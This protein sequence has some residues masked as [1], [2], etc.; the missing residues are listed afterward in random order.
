MNTTAPL[1][2]AFDAPRLASALGKQSGKRVEAGA[3]DVEGLEYSP[4]ERSMTFD[5][6]TARWRCRLMDYEV[7][8][9][10]EVEPA[11]KTKS[12]PAIPVDAVSDSARSPDG[13]WEAVV[14]G[15][16]LAVRERATG[17]LRILA[18]DGTPTDTY[19]KDV[20][21][22]RGVEMEYKAPAPAASLP[23]VVWSPDSTK[24]VAFRTRAGTS[25]VVYYV[26]SS[27]PDQLQPRLRSYP[28]LKP[29]DD[30]P[31]RRPHLFEVGTGRELPVSSELA[32]NP[33]SIDDVR[34]AP[35]SARFTYVYNERGHQTLRVIAVDGG[36]GASRPIVEERSRTFIDY[37]GKYFCE[38]LEGAGELLWMSEREGWNHLWLYDSRK[39]RLK[40]AVTH[41]DW[42]VRSV[43]RVDEERRQVW[44][45]AGGVVAGQDP[46]FLH[47]CRVNLDGTG[48]TVLTPEDGTHSAQFSP[49]RRWIIDTWSR[50]DQAP[51]H[52]LRRA[53]DGGLVVR[54]G[55]A[56]IS[57]LRADGWHPPEAFKARARDGE[58]EIYGIILRPKSYDPERKYPVLEEVYAGPQDS[59]VPK[60]FRAR[61]GAQSLA[62]RGFIVV[63]ADGLGTSNR[64]KRFHDYC[65]KNLADAGFAD[66]ILWIRA[67]AAKHPSFDLSR[68]GLYGTSAGGQTALGGMLLHGDFYKAGVADC[69]CHDNRMDK[70]WWNEQW[71]GWPVG[72]H[73]A[74]SSNVEMAS[75]LEG[76]L[77]LM[78][79]EADENVDPASTM[80]VVHALV[81]ADKDFEMFVMPG[82]GHGVAGTSYGKRKLENF[83]VRTFL[84]PNAKF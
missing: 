48:L 24:L 23:E 7:N 42:V 51:I 30:L 58:T 8:R 5:W 83:F 37:S 20:A 57:E 45:W 54:L 71:M 53:E 69:G 17:V 35:D 44:F 49:D 29:G 4:D 34:W 26:E 25:R 60:A 78:V 19:R 46:Y 1:A 10:V 47:L 36:T 6:G 12:E 39:G 66:R 40:N 32:P 43:E 67:A 82:A 84:D 65:W 22:D 80:Q 31:V 27:P 61:L 77:L 70:I 76:K 74:A 9:L 3:L 75:R 81:K 50:V 21:R 63:Q 72:P 28:Y 13:R 62:D 15:D 18:Y 14:H 11:S 41:G 56:D 64:S 59:Y 73:Y 55:E 2:P 68:V 16:N 52:E 33:W 38:H 79:G